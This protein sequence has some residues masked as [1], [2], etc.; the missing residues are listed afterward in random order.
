MNT[1]VDTL[2]A[3]SNIVELR[4]TDITSM[5]IEN[6]QTNR[7]GM[8][9]LLSKG[10]IHCQKLAENY[11]KASLALS[12]EV[13]LYYIILDKWDG[14]SVLE[15]TI[16]AVP[17]LYFVSS[18]NVLYQKYTGAYDRDTLVSVLKNN[19]SSRKR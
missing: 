17:T 2:S 16:R 4:P 12:N 9:A 19:L 10:C 15:K 5:K 13:Q 14:Q 3:Y 6:R 18:S 11:I 8:V 7:P 1:D